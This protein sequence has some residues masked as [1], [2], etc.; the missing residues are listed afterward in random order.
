[1]VRSPILT[2]LLHPLNLI[3]LVII[4]VAGLCSAWWLAPIGFILW[5]VM[6]LVIARDPGLQMTFTRQNRQTLS[7]RY[8]VRF[9]RLERA[10]FSVYNALGRSEAKIR[11]MAE[12]IVS[13]LDHL[14]DKAY[15]LSLGLSAVDNNFAVQQITNNFED[16]IAKLQKNMDETSDQNSRKEFEATLISLQKR[17][18]QL[19]EIST[20]LSRFEAQL[21]GT[22]HAV[23]SV[24]TGVISLQGRSVKNSQEKIPTL[25]EILR[26]ELVELDQFSDELAKSKI[27]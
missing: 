10:R 21:T 11:L 13:E 12:P 4:T 25:L 9:D 7:Q 20:L 3:M 14:V 17:Q 5:I 19:K 16:D 2:A 8:Q 23:D 22:T 27:I 26:T 18:T 1:M 6:V 24:V 15:Q